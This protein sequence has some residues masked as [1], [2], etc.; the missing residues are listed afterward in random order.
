MSQPVSRDGLD[1]HGFLRNPLFKS[2]CQMRAQALDF[3]SSFPPLDDL[4]ELAEAGFLSAPLPERFGGLGWGTEA[5]GALDLFEA[6]RLIGRLSLPLGEIYEAHV[7][8]VVLAMRRGSESQQEFVKAALLKRQLF[9]LWTTDRPG[10][11][12]RATAGLLQGGKTQCAGTGVVQQALVTARHDPDGTNE[13]LLAPLDQFS[14]RG[15]LSCWNPAGMRASARGNVDLTGLPVS[16]CQRLEPSQDPLSELLPARWRTLTVMLGGI[17]AVGEALRAHH[18]GHGN[19]SDPHMSSRLAKA[20]IAAETARLWCRQACW[21]SEVTNAAENRV[22][23]YMDL[24]RNSVEQAARAVLEAAGRSLPL[25]L[26]A[27]S[28]S[29]ERMLR[30]LGIYL[31]QPGLDGSRMAAARSMAG[32]DGHVGDLWP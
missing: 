13:L 6:L 16:V 1:L 23:G 9:G 32:L 12:L 8:A 15:D 14:E 19:G 4:D 29:V 21:L 26:L 31:C 10:A 25:Q 30:D 2:R 24:A 11:A 17:E 22:I 27:S 18:A 20:M 7:G 5:G 3:V 28:N